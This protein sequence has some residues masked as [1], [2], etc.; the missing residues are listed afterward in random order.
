M[1]GFLVRRLEQLGPAGRAPSSPSRSLVR[2]SYHLYYGW[3]VLPIARLGLGERARVPPLPAAGAVHR[4]A[5][6]LGSG[7]LLVPFFGGGPLG[8]EVLLL[9]PS[10]FVF[11]LVWRNRLARRPAGAAVGPAVA[12]R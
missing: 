7:P 4:R 5:R 9:A 12:G 10:T 1:L 11:W 2:I 6:A 8:V 3:G